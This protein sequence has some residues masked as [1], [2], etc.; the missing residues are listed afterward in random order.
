M[1]TKRTDSGSSE[2]PAVD[3]A[4]VPV[5]DPSKNVLDLVKASIE[6]IDDM[7]DLTLK[8]VEA[9]IA[10]VK[11]MATLRAEHTKA[12]GESETSRVN[13]VRQ[14]DVN[15]SAATTAQQ[16]AA[17]QALAVVQTANADK[18]NNTLN[19]TAATLAK[20]TTDLATTMATQ[21]AASFAAITERLAGL[22]RSMYEGKGKG[23]VEDPIRLDMLAE[24]KALRNA[25]ST[26][27]GSGEGMSKLLAI[28]LGVGGIII[29]A[30]TLI[31]KMGATP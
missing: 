2:G 8:Y 16:L 23:S 10:N 26:T 25:R 29:A 6:R 21:T 11:E 1:V 13:A 27:T 18:L 5:V 15:N 3:R 28:M 4:G 22:E 17:I 20:Q 30:V 12:M 19:T 9:E 7:R 24:I 31:V 14:V